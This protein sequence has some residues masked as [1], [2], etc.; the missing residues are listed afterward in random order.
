MPGLG[1]RVPAVRFERLAIAFPVD[2][3]PSLAASDFADFRQLR[4]PRRSSELLHLPRR[5]RE[6]QFVIFAAVKRQAQRVER[7][8]PH[9][10]PRHPRKSWTTAPPRQPVAT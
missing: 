10:T 7:L 6:Q 9:A 2:N 5:H 4:E 1:K 3:R 8:P